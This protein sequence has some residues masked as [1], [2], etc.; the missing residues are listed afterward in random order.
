M[1]PSKL[2]KHVIFDEDMFN[3][4]EGISG[5]SGSNFSAMINSALRSFIRER[6]LNNSQERDPVAELLSLRDR[7]RELLKE[8]KA[9]DLKKELLKKLG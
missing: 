1:K 8:I 3:F 9:L 2:R 7:E 6:L 5:D 4:F